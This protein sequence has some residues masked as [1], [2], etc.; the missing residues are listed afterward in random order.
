MDQRLVPHLGAEGVIGQLLGAVDC[1]AGTVACEGMEDLRMQPAPAVMHQGGVG[2]LMRQRVL[3]RVLRASDS[4]RASYRNSAARR[5]AMAQ[6]SAT[7]GA[8]AIGCSRNFERHPPADHRGALQ[9]ALRRGGR[10]S[11]RAASTA[12]TETGTLMSC[13][14]AARRS[15]P[16]SPAGSAPRSAHARFPPGTARCR[17][18]AVPD[19]ASTRPDRVRPSSAS[20]KMSI[21]AGEKR[22]RRICE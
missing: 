22:S 8:S 14:R 15:A 1:P 5:R 9:D 13:G 20:R 6:S 10:R 16:G 11:I 21:S 17:R 3:E 7:G 4:R 2:D 18:S 19:R 12:W